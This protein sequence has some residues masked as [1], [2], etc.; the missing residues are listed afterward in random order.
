MDDF[1]RDMHLQ[2]YE[3][4]G[5][6]YTKAIRKTQEKEKKRKINRF[7][8]SLDLSMLYEYF[9]MGLEVGAFVETR[10]TQCG[11]VGVIREQPCYNCGCP[12]HFVRQKQEGEDLFFGFDHEG[13]TYTFRRQNL[14]KST[15]PLQ[16][17]VYEKLKPTNRQE[18]QQKFNAFVESMNFKPIIDYFN[19]GL[20]LF[21]HDIFGAKRT[22]DYIYS[23]MREKILPQQKEEPAVIIGPL[24]VTKSKKKQEYFDETGHPIDKEAY[25]DIGKKQLEYQLKKMKKKRIEELE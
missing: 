5:V 19:Y 11:M 8:N 20:Q 13:Y 14:A 22:K 10:C 21:G 15:I 9:E 2:G 16:N 6:D 23:F 1:I 18:I 25:D 3:V 7:L 4:I 17:P 24:R 12:T